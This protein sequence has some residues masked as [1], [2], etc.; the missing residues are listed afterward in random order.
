MLWDYIED[1]YKPMVKNLAV[2]SRVKA[3]SYS[4][5]WNLLEQ[6]KRVSRK[7]HNGEEQ[8]MLALHMILS[9]LEGW[10]L[11]TELCNFIHREI[12]APSDRALEL[13]PSATSSVGKTMFQ[14]GCWQH[15]FTLLEG[16]A[17]PD[18]SGPATPDY[19]APSKY[20]TRFLTKASVY[21]YHC[22]YMA[23]LEIK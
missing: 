9:S 20:S 10:R 21:L 14:E 3:N 8:G 23:R 12:D 4:A 6:P 22:D 5:V 11:V 7:M 19:T 15:G 1:H 13:H 16:K 2:T 17:A 18:D